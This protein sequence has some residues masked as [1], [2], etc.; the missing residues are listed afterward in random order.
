VLLQIT[1]CDNPKIMKSEPISF[2]FQLKNGW[3][4][5]AWK[6]QHN[7]CRKPGDEAGGQGKQETSEYSPF[8]WLVKRRAAKA[9]TFLR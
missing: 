9:V 3:S 7:G 4:G 5:P 1:A 8:T 2:S 6:G